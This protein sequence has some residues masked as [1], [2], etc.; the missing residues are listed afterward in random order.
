MNLLAYCMVNLEVKNLVVR[1]D[2]PRGA[3]TLFS[4]SDPFQGES[5]WGL[6]PISFS[7]EKGQAIGIVGDNG[8]G[9]SSL[10]KAVAGLIP[11]EGEIVRPSKCLTAIDLNLLFH[12]DFSGYENLFMMNACHGYPDSHLHEI[13][14]TILE[15][16]AIGQF[17]HRPVREYS[18]GMRMR[19]GIAY[20]LY[21]QFDLLLI[22]EVLSVGDL[23]FQRQ[24]MGRMRDLIR[25]GASLLIASHNMSEIAHLCDELLLLESGQVIMHSDTDQVLGEYLKRCEEKGLYAPSVLPPAPRGLS[26]DQIN[27]EFV[28]LLNRD[29]H[30]V[31]TISSGETLKIE[32]TVKINLDEVYNPL[33]RLE[34]FRND[35]LLVMATNNYRLKER[36]DLGKGQATLVFEFEKLNLLASL[37]TISISIWPDEYASLVTNEAYDWRV[38]EFELI[39]RSHRSQGTGIVNSPAKCYLKA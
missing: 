33:F 18:A 37:Y 29:D 36:V 6:Q 1:Y 5:H 38:R 32:V 20:I 16:A 26:P 9:K 10:L 28:R 24:C 14:K 7:L 27:I 3:G 23:A 19:L 39:V 13:L 34:F 4:Q 25:E 17:I 2:T 31:K 22:D 30:E 11:F 21:Q 35:N 15:F 8:A 12:P